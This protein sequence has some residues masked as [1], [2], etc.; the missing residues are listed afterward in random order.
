MF[1]R[2]AFEFLEIQ[3]GGKAYLCCPSW[4]PVELDLNNIGEEWNSPKIQK[5][6]KSFLEGNYAFCT[7]HCPLVVE[8]GRNNPRE[9]GTLVSSGP[10]RIKFSFDRECN[11]YC[12]SCREFRSEYTEQD[13]R[14][15]Q[16]ILQILED[17]FSSSVE[18]IDLSGS[19]DPFFSYTLRN[20]MKKF[21]R[22]KYPNLKHV[23]LHTN[24]LLWTPTMWSIV[25]PITSYIKSAEISIDAACKETYNKVRRGGSWEKLQE[26][27]R[28]IDT[29][30][31]QDLCFSFV[32]QKDNYR[33]IVDFYDMCTK[34]MQMTPF[35]IRYAQVLDWGVP[36][37][38]DLDC[39]QDSKIVGEIKEQIQEV[40][41][42]TR[43]YSDII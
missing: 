40:K 10:K 11:L 19:G 41:K 32:V 28:F 23:H 35:S 4:L 16:E 5:I 20:W 26:N 17:H 15:S 39:F 12:K 38:Q 34:A 3:P 33:E 7:E 2:N 30:M 43:V 37:F 14:K 42:H 22:E 9:D 13:R 29:L 36:Y 24:A 27:L 21:S 6:R 1:C 8:H 31:L 25:E 18:R